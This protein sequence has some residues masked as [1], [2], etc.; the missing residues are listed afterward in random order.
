MDKQPE[1]RQQAEAMYAAGQ[2]MQAIAKALGVSQATITR[3]L[4]GVV[5]DQPARPK[6]GRPKGGSTR[7]T[8]AERE[9]D[10][11]AKTEEVR[12]RIVAK[13]AKAL[14]EAIGAERLE[15]EVAKRIEATAAKAL[16]EAMG[17]KPAKNA[18]ETNGNA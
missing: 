15:A 18:G 14:R 10:I 9:A 11:Q 2:T 8:R 5:V 13:A 1:R 7:R 4:K 3:D 16:H 17:G 6:G 12:R